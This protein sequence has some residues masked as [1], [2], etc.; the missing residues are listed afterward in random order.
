MS[1]LETVFAKANA[2]PDFIGKLIADPA[3]ACRSAGIT[4]NATELK[5]LVAAV[6]DA[7]R[8]FLKN[9]YILSKGEDLLGQIGCGICFLD[10]V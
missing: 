1:I 7:K 9:L 2:E 4:P 5:G 3:A 6:S 8:Y 10:Q